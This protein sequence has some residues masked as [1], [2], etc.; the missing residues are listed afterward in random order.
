[1]RRQPPT[2]RVLFP[3]AWDLIQ[4][5]GHPILFKSPYRLALGELEEMGCGWDIGAAGFFA[6]AQSPAFIYAN[7]Q[8][9]NH[10]EARD[11]IPWKSAESPLRSRTN[12]QIS[13]SL[14]RTRVIA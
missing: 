7:S 13:I 10:R 5:G 4:P 12:S 11:K 14:A 8:P 1:M 3:I 2:S 6:L 9:S